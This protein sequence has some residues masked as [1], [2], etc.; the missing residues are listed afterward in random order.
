MDQSS[1]VF[2]LI[3]GWIMKLAPV[4]AFGAMAY[5]VGRYGLSSLASYGKLIACCYLAAVLFILVLAAVVRVFAGVNLRTNCSS[6]SAP[7]PPRS[8]CRAS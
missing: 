5:I 2:F 3:I 4:G 1:H 8:C 6:H 7:P